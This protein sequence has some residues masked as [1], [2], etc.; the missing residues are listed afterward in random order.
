MTKQLVAPSPPAPGSPVRHRHLRRAAAVAGVAALIAAG[1]FAATTIFGPDSVAPTPAPAP[2]PAISP[3]PPLTREQA[4]REMRDAIA[5][6]YGPQAGTTPVA[7]D[8]AM[9][10][11]REAIARVYA[12]QPG[13]SPVSPEQAMREMRSTITGLYGGAR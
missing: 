5:R 2:A 3:T 6:A 12:P 4:L 13:R 8:Q 1:G 9:R 11:M 10:E 7:R